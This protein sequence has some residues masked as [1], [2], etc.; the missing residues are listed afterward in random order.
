MSLIVCNGAQEVNI[1]Q[2]AAL[3]PPPRTRS[4]RPTRYLDTV[5]FVKEAIDNL[6]SLEFK[7]ERFALNKEG[8]QFFGE[9]VYEGNDIMDITFGL[10]D[11]INK[12]VSKALAVGSSVMVCANLCV[13]GDMYTVMRKNTTHQWSD[14]RE[15]VYRQVENMQG[16]FNRMQI[17]ANSFKGI[18][19]NI[20]R[21]FAFLGV[22]RGRGLLTANQYSTALG[23]WQEP[24]HEDFADRNLWSLYNCG[25]EGLKKGDVGSVLGRHVGWHS[26]ML[27][28]AQK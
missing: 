14:F 5:E 18:P 20:D 25:N 16:G 15:I 12:S 3:P 9:L 10:R 1:A 28:A 21:G 8:G 11:S 23:D 13:S 22:A 26:Y 27:E 4:H 24:R 17:A 6:T 7:R 2:L 19:C